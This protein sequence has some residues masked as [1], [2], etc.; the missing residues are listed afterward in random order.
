MA[1]PAAVGR[2]GSAAAGGTPASTAAAPALGAVAPRGAIRGR[3]AFARRAQ[4]ERLG[5][6]DDLA[7]PRRED[8]DERPDRRQV[9]LAARPAV[10][11]EDLGLA[12]AVDVARPCPSSAPSTPRT[13]QPMT[14]CQ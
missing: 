2:V 7:A 8:P 4:V 13:A 10:D 9:E 6:D 12:D 3:A 1:R 14:S 11:D 5:V